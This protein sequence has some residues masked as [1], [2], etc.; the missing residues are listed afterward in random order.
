VGKGEHTAAIYL[1]K[2]E[3]NRNAYEEHP[4]PPSSRAEQ[5]TQ[6]GCGK[7]GNDMEGREWKILLFLLVIAFNRE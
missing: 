2:E 4:V 3:S 7:K 1:E 6:V 5:H